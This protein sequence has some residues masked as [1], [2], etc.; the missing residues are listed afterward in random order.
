MVPGTWRF[1]S[2]RARART[3]WNFVGVYVTLACLAVLVLHGSAPP[4]FDV[5]GAIFLGAAIVVV[6]RRAASIALIANDTQVTIKNQYRTWVLNWREIDRVSISSLPAPF[7][8]H[9]PAILFVTNEGR[10]IKAQAVSGKRWEQEAMLKQLASAAPDPTL[11]DTR[12]KPF[13][14]GSAS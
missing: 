14:R 8:S 5:A 2:T 4:Y 7:G 1:R 11:V 12:V 10:R 9:R 3:V 6:L 13:D